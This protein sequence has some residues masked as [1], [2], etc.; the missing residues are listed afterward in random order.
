MDQA[1][2]MAI[3]GFCA[4]VYL[5]IERVE[6]EDATKKAQVIERTW[7][8][9]AGKHPEPF[10]TPFRTMVNLMEP[11]TPVQEGRSFHIPKATPLNLA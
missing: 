11:D 1:G 9:M 5:S 3:A 6:P 4:L 7:Q 10:Q 2:I 8:E